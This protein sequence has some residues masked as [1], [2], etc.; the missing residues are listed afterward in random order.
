[1]RHSGFLI[2]LFG[3]L[4]IA[5]GCSNSQNDDLAIKTTTDYGKE[6]ARRVEK[7]GDCEY[8]ETGY[9]NSNYGFSFKYPNNWSIRTDLPTDTT[10]AVAV[11]RND[12]IGNTTPILG[13]HVDK[14]DPK[15]L[16]TRKSE[17]E[18]EFQ[19]TSLSN[20]KFLAFEQG[21]LSDQ[22]TLFVRYTTVTED[23]K[24]RECAQYIFNNQNKCYTL[25]F[26]SPQENE[27]VQREM[28]AI[29]ATF[30]IGQ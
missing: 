4:F 29:L 15:L 24:R 25:T 27:Q 30:K 2:V 14:A 7:S 19:S 9:T 16:E 11:T 13:I 5:V 20:V 3:L 21:K 18:R 6:A 1:M 17:F 26:F 22:D 8:S 28:D 12:A 10:I 23:N